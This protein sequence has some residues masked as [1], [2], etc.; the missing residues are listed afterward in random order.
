MYKKYLFVLM[1]VISLFSL[2]VLCPVVMACS[3]GKVNVSGYAQSFVWDKKIKDAEI[4]LSYYSYKVPDLNTR[5]DADGRFSFCVVP[6]KYITLTLNKNSRSPLDDYKTTQT[7][8]YYVPDSGLQGKYDEITF[9]VPRTVTF[10]ILKK[11][12]EL[13]RG[14]TLDPNDCQLAMTITDYHKTLDDLPQ[15]IEGSKVTIDNHILPYYRYNQPFY[16]GIY[17]QKTWP[18]SGDRVTTSND[19]GVVVYNIQPGPAMRKIGA[20]KQGV[21]FSSS[22]FVC[23]GGAFINISPPRSPSKDAI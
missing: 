23:T 9:Q 11:V 4:V 16:F 12:I 20:Y 15:G 6:G 17:N 21:T 10:S 3:D 13:S 19:G 18:F 2:F 22:H 5:T 7:G 14:V 1:A 8:T